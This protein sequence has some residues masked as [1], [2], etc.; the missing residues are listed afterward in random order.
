MV[1]ILCHA[2]F[3]LLLLSA[4]PAWAAGGAVTLVKQPKIAG[5][6]AFPRIATPKDEAEKRI[7]AALDRQD[8][9]LRKGVAACRANGKHTSWERTVT[10]PMTGPFYLSLI[11]A[12]YLDCGGA[13]PDTGQLV[14]VYD[15]QTGR[16][17]NWTRLLPPDLAA[18]V[19]LDDAA[20][21]TKIGTVTSP[22][23]L[24]LYKAGYPA[25]EDRVTCL[26]AIGDGPFVLWPDAKA[27][28]LDVAPSSLPHVMAACG[29][30]VTIPVADLRHLGVDTRLTDAIDAAHAK[31]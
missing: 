10:A 9:Q 29:E 20:D 6:D 15:L 26:D 27:R 4:A 28:G 23:L 7:N 21:G 24:A 1:K 31:R 5:A 19:A 14:L 22:K 17:V 25:G 8:S 30:I 16:P 18:T 12:D 11:A 13:H 2:V 3:L